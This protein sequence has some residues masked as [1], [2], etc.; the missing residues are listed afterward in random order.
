MMIGKF[1]HETGHRVST[2]I[3][4]YFNIFVEDISS[5]QLV[6]PVERDVNESVMFEYSHALSGKRQLVAATDCNS[7]LG[8][9]RR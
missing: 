5:T 2:C 6:S 4:R 1:D 9:G 7:L 8:G 3:Q